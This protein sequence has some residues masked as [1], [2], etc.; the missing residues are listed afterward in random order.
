MTRE[1]FQ[2]KVLKGRSAETFVCEDLIKKKLIILYRNKRINGV[3]VDILA[4][5]NN[6]IFIIEVK[7]HYWVGS[8]FEEIISKDQL[9]RLKKVQRN[10]ESSTLFKVSL[11]LAHLQNQ[12]IDFISL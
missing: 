9:A 5:K 11:I 8:G 2:N 3:E 12:K 4:K 1:K 6:E 7:K 10:L